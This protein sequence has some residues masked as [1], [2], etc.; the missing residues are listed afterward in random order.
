MKETPS[1]TG[2]E[3]RILKVTRKSVLGSGGQGTLRRYTPSSFPFPCFLV[4]GFHRQAQEEQII[5]A[6]RLETGVRQWEIECQSVT[7][8]QGFQ[9]THRLAQVKKRE[10]WHV[11][12]RFVRNRNPKLG[13]EERILKVTRKSGNRGSCR[14]LSL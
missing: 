14:K 3:E 11:I 12:G 9:E 5:L 4:L 2:R 13:R 1:G 10:D 6:V 7:A 8:R